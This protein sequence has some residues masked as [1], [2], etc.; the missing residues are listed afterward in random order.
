V[1]RCRL[2][3]VL[4]RYLVTI[5]YQRLAFVQLPVV[6]CTVPERLMPARHG[7]YRIF[8]ATSFPESSNR[9][10]GVERP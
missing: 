4:P 2:P 8:V 6:E 3:A 10:P 9:I 7:F 1:K 5:V